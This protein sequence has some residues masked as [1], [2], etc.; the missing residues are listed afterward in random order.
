MHYKKDVQS[1]GKW[2]TLIEALVLTLEVY[3]T[4]NW[5]SKRSNRRQ[6]FL[7]KALVLIL[8]LKL[9]VLKSIRRSI[10]VQIDVQKCL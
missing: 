1:P 10:D 6:K 5:R 3:Q 7:K 8:K 4:F 9:F 2:H